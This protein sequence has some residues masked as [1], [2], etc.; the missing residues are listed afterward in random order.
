M[1]KI[2]NRGIYK[3]I[4]SPSLSDFLLGTKEE[5]G[6][7]KSFPLQSVIQLI[8]GVNG[9]NNIQYKFSDGSDPD[10]DYTTSGT[11]FT[12]NNSTSLPSFTELIFNKENLQI[13][14]RSEHTTLHNLNKSKIIE[15][16]NKIIGVLK[17]DELLENLE[18]DNQQPSL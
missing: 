2:N 18:A 8:N 4:D 7:T 3:N 1:A 6:S 10:I 11:F 5:D 13:L 9:K 14:T 17:Q 15:K 16:Y 12:N